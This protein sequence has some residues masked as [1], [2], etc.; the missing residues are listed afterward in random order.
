[1]SAAPVT[2]LATI[3]GRRARQ[4]WEH[5]LECDPIVGKDILELLSSGMYVDARTVFRELIQNSADAIDEAFRAGLFREGQLARV[6]ILFDPTKRTVR[7]RDNGIGVPA[8]RAEMVLT[9]FGASAKRGTG[10]RGFRGVGR[11]AAFAY[12]QSVSFKT[13]AVGETVSTEI[14][15]D[16][17]RLK[18][19]LADP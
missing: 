13:K 10:A 7:V 4:R 19:A 8:S 9:S 15:W 16:C 2:E 3:T 18:S 11:L 17:R 1:M 14:R 6:D 5:A 12:A